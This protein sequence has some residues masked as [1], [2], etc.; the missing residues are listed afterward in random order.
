MSETTARFAIPLLATGQ[1]QKDVTH[2]EALTLTDVLLSPVVQSVAPA[3]I[4]ASPVPGQGWIVGPSPQGAWAGRA[5]QIA[6]WTVGG[7]RFSAAPV[8]MAI[9]SVAD[10]VTV[11][12]TPSGWEIGRLDASILRIGGKQLVGQRLA[13]VADPIAGTTVDTE[14]RAS[15]AAILDR[16]RMHGLIEI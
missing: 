8:G 3:A 5:D 9:W 7:W 10:S 11:R 12:M 2:N 15:I 13:A 4:P 14:A 1:A 6:F 16:L